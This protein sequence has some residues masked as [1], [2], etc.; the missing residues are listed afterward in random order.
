MASNPLGFG[1]ARVYW[2]LGQSLL[3]EHFYAQEYSLRQETHL[4]LTRS[5]PP[6][7]GLLDIEWDN[8]QFAEGIIDLKRLVVVMPN[9]LVIDIPGN[10]RP[11][12][13]NLNSTGASQIPLYLHLDSDF[14]IVQDGVPSDAGDEGVEK[15]VHRVSLSSNPYSETAAQ[16]F[17]LGHF[18]KSVDGGWDL[19]MAFIPATIAVQGSPFFA[20]ILKRARAAAEVAHQILVDDIEENYLGGATILSAKTCLKG[21]YKL[22]SLLA[23]IDGD[24]RFHPFDVF[25]ALH[26]FYL[27]VTLYRESKPTLGELVYRHQELGSVF[28]QL[29]HELE[30]LLK[31]SRTKTPYSPFES[32]DGVWRCALPEDIRQAK[33]VYWL[34]QKDRVGSTVDL[35][36]FKLAAESRVRLVHQLSLGG[37][38]VERI[39]NPPFHHTFGSEVEFYKLGSGQ[40]WDFAVQD[41]AVAFFD[42][43]ALENTRSFMFWRIE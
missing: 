24:V 34:V 31:T 9:G 15:I 36:G 13:F 43:P 41:G 14:D 26:E 21:L 35:Q 2:K 8:F 22:K 23:N 11:A 19:D 39:E 6:Q 27:D 33:D 12:G 16:T 37:I 42:R 28:N 30:A 32:K 1:T 18:S 4:K 7:W 25:Q 29:I 10:T 17:E 20:P 38:P 5:G 3:P 40:E